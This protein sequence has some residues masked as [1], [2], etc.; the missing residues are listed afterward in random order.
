MLEPRPAAPGTLDNTHLAT[1][2]SDGSVVVFDLMTGE[3]LKF[4]GAVAYVHLFC[5]CC[6]W[7]CFNVLFLFFL[8]CGVRFFV[9]LVKFI[10]HLNYIKVFLFFL[11]REKYVRYNTSAIGIF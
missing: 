5:Y 3:P 9:C 2:Y 7:I 11:S 10:K 1:G 4:T 8:L 6:S